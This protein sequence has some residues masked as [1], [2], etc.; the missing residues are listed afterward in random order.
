MSSVHGLDDSPLGVEQ[1]LARLRRSGIDGEVRCADLFDPP[2]EWLGAFDIVSWF[3]V[4]EHFRDT[5]AAISAAAARRTRRTAS[6]EPA[7][8]G[9]RLRRHRKM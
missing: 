7:D 1:T 3:G 8:R 9:V 4:A 2:S 6:T 5:S